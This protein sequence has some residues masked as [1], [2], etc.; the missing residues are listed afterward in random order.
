MIHGPLA[1]INT[2]YPLIV[3]KNAY[4]RSVTIEKFESLKT[5]TAL[6]RK[7]WECSK[8]AFAKLDDLAIKNM[9]FVNGFS[10]NDHETGAS[11]REMKSQR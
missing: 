10:T 3:G 8:G 4:I 1:K 9:G 11:P 2:Q 6:P 7:A 5:W